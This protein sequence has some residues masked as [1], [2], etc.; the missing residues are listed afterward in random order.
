MMASGKYN[1]SEGF[2]DTQEVRSRDSAAAMVPKIVEL[3]RPASVIDIGCGVGP[4]LAEFRKAGVADCYGVDGPWVDPKR[5][6]LEPARLIKFDFANETA[7][8]RPH[9][10]LPRYDLVL[11][12]E[13]L[14][15]IQPD[16]APALVAFMAS[17]S[18]AIVMSAA[19]PGQGGTHHVNEQW[20]DYW[21]DMFRPFGYHPFDFLR[22]L[23]WDDDRIEP[24]YRQ[25]MVGLFRGKVPDA[26]VAAAES[27]ALARLRSPGRVVHPE[28][29]AL[30]GRRD[31]WDLPRQ[32]ANRM[33]HPQLR[34]YLKKSLPVMRANRQV[35]R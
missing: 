32:I 17:L 2:Y 29:F 5:F 7:P 10:P 4:W 19:L 6:A 11:T 9:L 14:E 22:P 23:F 30:A 20:I 28:I 15:H 12:L 25:N 16:T 33:I 18:D 31:P 21:T 35:A 24:W 34:H 13:F 26:L 8:F 3:L 27:A 1:Y